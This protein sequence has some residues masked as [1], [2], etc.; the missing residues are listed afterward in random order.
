M[1]IKIRQVIEFNSDFQ[2]FAGFLNH[3][4]QQSSINANVK[5]QNRKVILEIDETDKEKV[6]KFSDEVTKYLPHSL[7]LGEIDT[8]NFDGDL[9]KHNSISPDYEIAPCNFCI[10]ELSNETSPH[11]LDNGYRCSHY[12]NKG[13]LFLEDEFTYSPNYSENSILLLTNSAKF[14][15]L[16]IATDDEKKALFSIEKPTLKLTIRNQ[17]LKELTGKK[18]LFVKAPWS[19]KSV[20][21]AI[22]SKESGFDYLFFN[23]NDD[24][25]AIVIQDNISFIKANRLLP[26]LK[27]LHENR[28]L[29]R[30]LNILD[31][32]NFKNGIG[33]YLN[34]KSGSI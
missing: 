15:E 1:S 23:D 27:N 32:A 9:E 6:Q 20:L 28:L 4:V 14:D 13:E 19:V 25:K 22:Q 33:I 7:F 34:D 5:F 17:E 31:E 21:V 26:K 8:S 30:F 16:F 2:Y 24:L 18:Y 12:S 29:N 10:E 3:I 11:Y